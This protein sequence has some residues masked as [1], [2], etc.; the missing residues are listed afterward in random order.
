MPAPERRGH[1]RIGRGCVSPATTASARP[2][3]IST[4]RLRQTAPAK[5][6]LRVPL[7]S[8]PPGPLAGGRDLR[9]RGPGLPNTTLFSV[10]G[11]KAETAVIAFDLAR[12]R[13]VIGAA[14]SSARSSPRTSWRRWASHWIW[15]AARC[16]S[17]LARPRPNPR[18][19]ASW[20][21]GIQSQIIT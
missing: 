12:R 15:P 2:D 19:I 1:R 14:C 20:K 10:P 21:L 17:A 13:R 4:T 11:L 5:T 8:R 3:R 9:S 6:A 7:E 18:S 16:A